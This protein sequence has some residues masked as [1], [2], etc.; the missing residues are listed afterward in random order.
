MNVA[1]REYFRRP[2]ATGRPYLSDVFMGR[3][4]GEDPIVAIS[5]PWKTRDGAFG[6]VVEGSLD[7]ARLGQAG[8]IFQSLP[9]VEIFIVDGRSQLL[10]NGPVGSSK[11]LAPVVIGSQ[12]AH[13]AGQPEVPALVGKARVPGTDWTVA[14]QQPVRE[15]YRR[16]VPQAAIT[17]ALML[18]AFV[19]IVLLTSYLA[20]RVTRP[21]EELSARLDHIEL[22]VAPP[23]LTPVPAGAPREIAVRWISSRTS[24][25]GSRKPRPRRPATRGAPVSAWPSPK[26]SSSATAAVSGLR[27]PRE[28]APRL[29]L[30]CRREKHQSEPDVPDPVRRTAPQPT[31]Q[32]TYVRSL[33]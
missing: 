1:D 30:L 22:G 26:R 33:P 13:L 24:S 6:G 27:P 16:A 14:V 18:A 20:R 28:S 17:L 9:A 3:V 11:P 2:H 31:A 7:L 10:W 4:F 21:L 23:V 32:P 19:F 12:G 25:R 8:S 15:I 5:A 29:P